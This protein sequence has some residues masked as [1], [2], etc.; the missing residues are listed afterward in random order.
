MK[1]FRVNFDTAGT[2]GFSD[3]VLVKDEKDIETALEAKKRDFK[4]NTSYCRV[5]RKIEVP[6]SQVKISELS[7][8]EFFLLIGGK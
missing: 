1:A 2:S 8:T 7:I 4:A 6:L 5:T 3:V